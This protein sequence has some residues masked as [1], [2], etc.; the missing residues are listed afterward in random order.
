MRKNF[1]TLQVPKQNQAMRIRCH[2][3]K[4]KKKKKKKPQE[5]RS[6]ANNTESPKS[7]KEIILK[8]LYFS[9]TQKRHV[10]YHSLLSLSRYL[11]N[12]YL[13]RLLDQGKLNQLCI[14]VMI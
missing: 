6:N 2:Q 7:V 4:K 3:K 1:T 8:L 5:N 9:V 13:V 10:L 14:P 11:G 12:K